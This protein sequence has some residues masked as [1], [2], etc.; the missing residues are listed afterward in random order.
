MHSL[1]RIAVPALVVAITIGYLPAQG[2]AAS[3]DVTDSTTSA[4]TD[5]N[6]G[7]HGMSGMGGTM[8]G[9]MGDTAMM[10]R[11][12]AHLAM[13]DTASAEHLKAL[14]S[15]HRQMVATMLSRFRSEM[16]GMNM[17][18][19]QAWKA[20]VDSLR[21]DLIHMPAMSARELKAFMS[22]HR[23]RVARLMDMHRG[24]M[25]RMH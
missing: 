15:E 18:G 22:Q 10:Q 9:Q 25:D 7:M 8:G 23:A 1:F 14:L 11:M 13:M 20:T 16:A 5:T 19:D 3:Q 12:R 6:H 2:A 24:M 4:P 17:A 21:Q